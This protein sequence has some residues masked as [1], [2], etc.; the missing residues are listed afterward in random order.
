MPDR[1][2]QLASPPVLSPAQKLRVALEMAD[3]GIAMKRRSL[4]RA[5]PSA[6]DAQ[7]EERLW[8]WLAEPR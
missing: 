7:I 6:S 5:D 8:D 1:D 2:L 3:Q 4:R